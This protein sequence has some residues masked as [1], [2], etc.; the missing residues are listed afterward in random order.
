MNLG[1]RAK[2]LSEK[3]IEQ[4]IDAAV[5]FSPSN[6]RYCTDFRM[7]KAVES[8]LLITAGGEIS[9][10]V[11]KLDFNRAITYCRIENIIPFPEDNPNY[12][13]PLKELFKNKNIKKI[14][15]EQDVITF[16]K[17]KF[18]K[19]VSNA[20]IVPID[21]ML[22]SLRAIKTNEEIELI[23]KAADIAD[24]AMR[25][26]LKLLT[27]G[28]TEAEISAYAKYIMEK[29]GAE[30]TSFE[31]FVMSGQNAWLPQRFSSS[32]KITKGEL[33]IFD[34]GAVYMGY[35][36]DLTRTFSLGGLNDRQKRIFDTAYFAQREAIKAIKPGVR[37][38]DIDRI[39]RD[40]IIESGYGQYFPHLTG[41]GLGISIHES[42]I[43]DIGMETRLKPNMIVTV[44]PGIYVD[45]IGAARV[46]DMVLITESGYEVLT[47]TDRELEYR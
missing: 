34:M 2:K 26:S 31:P 39:A 15:V 41:H 40:I 12:L 19:E 30:G 24:K 42:P 9:Y 28:I 33:C 13:L 16:Y 18:L 17:L 27:E 22:V 4:K 20:D 7:N 36:S 35:C 37:A 10:I 47:K 14:G 44:E 6:I 45:G 5:L 43:L 1:D 32:K 3:L 23:R 25:E 38:C 46:E 8:I 11:P 21:E 29:E